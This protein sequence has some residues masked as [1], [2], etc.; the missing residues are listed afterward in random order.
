MDVPANESIYKIPV[1]LRR[2]ILS[3]IVLSS[4]ALTLLSF[5]WLR[6]EE[7][8]FIKTD[9]TRIA[10]GRF[11]SLERAVEQR[12]LKLRSLAVVHQSLGK[13][14]RKRFSAIIQNLDFDLEEIRSVG[15]IPKVPNAHR[16]AF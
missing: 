13:I 10:E 11:A 3:L 14:E 4:V 1:K 2:R 7:R 5:L 16:L 12:L 8:Q 9:F 15:W 6:A